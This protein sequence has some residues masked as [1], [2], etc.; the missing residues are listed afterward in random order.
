LGCQTNIA[1]KVLDRGGDYL[2]AVK[3]NQ[4][5]L[6]DEVA[7]YFSDA[8]PTTLDTVQTTGGDHGRIEARSHVVS[9]NVDWM[10]TDRRFP[11]EHASPA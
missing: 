7:K 2:L 1:Q 11:G 3:D 5:S 9:T 4:P 6:H 10:D 8:D